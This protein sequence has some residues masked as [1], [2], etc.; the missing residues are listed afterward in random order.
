MSNPAFTRSPYFNGKQTTVA[1]NNSY[2]QTGQYGQY[3]QYGQYG[4]YGQTNAYGAQA[5]QL[6][7]MYAAPSASPVQT[8]RMTY[9]DVLIKS[10][11]MLA[12]LLVSAVVGW[13][14]TPAFPH[15]CWVGM[16]TGFVLCLVNS[17]KR[18]PSPV[19]ITLYAAAEGLFL[20]GLSMLF[21]AIW[22][23]IIIQAV[24]A[25]FAVF[26]IT[27]ALFAS[28]KVRA[29]GRAARIVLVALLAYLVYALVNFFMVLAGA[30]HSMFGLDTDIEVFGVPLG[31]ILGPIVILLGAYCLVLSFDFIKRG[32][33]GGIPARYAWQ[34]AFGLLVDLVFLYFHILRVLA[35]LRN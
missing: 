33:E 16:I 1:P 2:G 7:A 3:D 27:L 32:V 11:G 13:L 24:L 8:G 23:G 28:G 22:P 12:V 30:T 29:S 6:N 26:G 9:D 15:L 34:A 20:G 18:E 35:I 19:L 31:L 21:E 4:Q 10:V 25:T 5:P 14:F 17:F